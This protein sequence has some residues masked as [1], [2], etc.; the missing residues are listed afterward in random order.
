MR[1][2]ND[3]SPVKDNP[4]LIVE[5]LSLVFGEGSQQA[6]ALQN[7][8]FTVKAGEFLVFMGLPRSGKS[9]LF[10]CLNG[11]NG[12]KC[13]GGRSGLA[14]GR[15][16]FYS[17]IYSEPLD[18]F[19][20]DVKQLQSFRRNNVS[21]VSDQVGLFPWLTVRQNIAFPLILRNLLKKEIRTSVNQQIEVA[22]LS[23]CLNC[24]PNELSEGMRQRVRL[25]RA[26]V[27]NSDI[28][29]MDDP[30]SSLSSEEAARLQVE[31][32]KL[33][34]EFKKT[35]LFISQNAEE[36]LKLADRIAF[37]ESGSIVQIDTPDN[38]ISRPTSG[39]VKQLLLGGRS[40]FHS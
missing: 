33:Q 19:D 7:V 39:V 15:I 3:K 14:H 18:I 26:F 21:I 13:G 28:L 2:L 4:I 27:S 1:N 5:G 35:I 10:R 17:P 40:S 29:L 31:V 22:A 9:S 25:A 6:I 37:M 11:M 12:N 24:Y 23:S 20:C 30:F 36:A 8:S 34:N 38:C 32:V 16:V